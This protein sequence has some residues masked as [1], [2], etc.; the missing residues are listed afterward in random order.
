MNSLENDGSPTSTSAALFHIL[1]IIPLRDTTR[2]HD[3]TCADKRGLWIVSIVGVRVPVDRHVGSR[4]FRATPCVCVAMRA[5]HLL[6]NK[7]VSFFSCLFFHSFFLFI[8]VIQR[9]SLFLFEYCSSLSYFF[10][11]SR[12][13]LIRLSSSLKSSSILFSSNLLQFLFS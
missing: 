7:V 8:S 3:V 12:S 9:S 6:L 2:S 5:T 13:P 1:L 10:N 4:L 11:K